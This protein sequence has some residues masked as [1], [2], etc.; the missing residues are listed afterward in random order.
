MYCYININGINQGELIDFERK[1]KDEVLR[2]LSFKGQ[3]VKEF[4]QE[5]QDK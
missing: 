4:S 3:V 1:K 5:D 2:T